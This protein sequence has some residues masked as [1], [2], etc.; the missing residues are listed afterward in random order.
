MLIGARVAVSM[1]GVCLET[2]INGMVFGIPQ[3]GCQDMNGEFAENKQLNPDVEVYNMP[4][5]YLNG[6]DRQ[7]ERAVREMMKK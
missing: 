2:L 5:D 4:E 6:Y 1:S 3:V 7:L